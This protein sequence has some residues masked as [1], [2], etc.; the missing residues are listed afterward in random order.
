MSH[1]KKME[2]MVENDSKETSDEL[3]ILLSGHYLFH[4][5]NL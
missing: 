4:Q 3:K 2:K 1:I 5:T